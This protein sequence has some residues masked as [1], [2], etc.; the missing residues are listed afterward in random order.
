MSAPLV[1]TPLPAQ[2]PAR[3]KALPAAGPKPKPARA[4]KPKASVEPA[5]VWTGARKKIAVN[6]LQMS[7]PGLGQLI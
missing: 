2:A 4:S 1:L 7:L 3:R 5:K 6:H